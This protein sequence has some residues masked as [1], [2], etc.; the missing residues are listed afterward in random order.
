MWL[1]FVALLNG[2][3]G[4]ARF[5]AA[6]RRR[7]PRIWLLRFWLMSCA[8]D[9][10]DVS[11]VPALFMPRGARGV[12]VVVG[13]ER[14]V[15]TG[16]R[17]SRV[18][19]PP[20]AA[21]IPNQRKRRVHLSA[22]NAGT[23]AV[24]RHKLLPACILRLPRALRSRARGPPRLHVCAEV[25]QAPVEARRVAFG[26]ALCVHSALRTASRD[27]ARCQHDRNPICGLMPAPQ[28]HNATRCER[29]VG[30]CGSRE[31]VHGLA[32]STSSEKRVLSCC[33]LRRRGKALH[34]LHRAHHS[35]RSS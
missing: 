12:Y 13:A 14:A 7:A 20:H 16:L 21:R 27:I 11:A 5:E 4:G 28:R 15:P 3:A 34:H 19:T 6:A 30:A 17:L 33:R 10:L 8:H 24:L 9:L 32:H 2:C 35:Q 18:S 1:A 26:T 22:P 29:S 25:L 23:F 31:L